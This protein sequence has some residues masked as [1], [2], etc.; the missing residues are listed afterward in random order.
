[1]FFFVNLTPRRFVAFLAIRS[2]NL[3]KYYFF[4][5]HTYCASDACLMR[6]GN[7]LNN[8]SFFPINSRCPPFGVSIQLHTFRTVTDAT[9]TWRE[10]VL[11]PYSLTEHNEYVSN[12]FTPESIVIP[13][14]KTV[15]VVYV[16]CYVTFSRLL[17]HDIRGSKSGVIELKKSCSTPSIVKGKNKNLIVS[18]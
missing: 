17:T 10:Y 4:Y 13:R 16:W 7:E 18:G 14:P 5:S 3:K 11:F 2:F 1:V 12:V 6:T 9:A 15:P 8:S